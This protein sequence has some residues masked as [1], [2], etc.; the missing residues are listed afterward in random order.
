[1][2]GESNKAQ[3][4]LIADCNVGL[5]SDRSRAFCFDTLAKQ[6]PDTPLIAVNRAT[7]VICCTSVTRKAMGL[8]QAF[9]Y[10]SSS[11]APGDPKFGATTVVHDAVLPTSAE[12]CWP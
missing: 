5:M 12:G 4:V 2:E 6:T 8:L 7:T 10:G 1:M 3:T 11:A 9:G